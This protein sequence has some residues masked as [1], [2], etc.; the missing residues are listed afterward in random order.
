MVTAPAWKGRR[1]RFVVALS[2]K[3][4]RACLVVAAVLALAAPQAARADGKSGQEVYETVCVA[5]HATGE[6]K[7]P[8]F[9][10]AK[11]WKPLIAEGQRA[12]VRT[13]IKGIREM[14]PRGGNPTLADRE[15]ERAVVYMVNA[16]G[17]KFREPK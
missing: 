16:A 4:R 8:R 15:V 6:R 10:D 5:C 12:L 9:G 1:A 11:A 17:G 2:G 7:A 14:P 3:G 13:A